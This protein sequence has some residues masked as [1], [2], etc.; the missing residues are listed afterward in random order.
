MTDLT[1]A[2]VS[3]YVRHV[4]SD[5][6]T[7]LKVHKIAADL[8]TSPKAVG[9]YLQQLQDDLPG[10]TLEPWGRSKSITWCI[11]QVSP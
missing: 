4:A 10:V 8:N 2:A 9:Q 7:Y 1:K 11:R 6:P 3:D 5:E